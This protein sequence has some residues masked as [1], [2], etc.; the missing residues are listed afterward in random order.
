MHIFAS[1]QRQCIAGHKTRAAGR[2]FFFFLLLTTVYA[3]LALYSDS[4]YELGLNLAQ[5]RQ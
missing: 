4:F 2:A 3:S 1:L 5:G